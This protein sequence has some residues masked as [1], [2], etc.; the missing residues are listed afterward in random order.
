MRLL[1]PPRF[2]DELASSLWTRMCRRAGL[3]I[4]FLTTRLLGR[5]WTPGFFQ[6]GHIAQMADIFGLSPERMLSL[7]TVFPYATAFMTPEVRES[8]LRN[9][10][11]V[12]TTAR[13]AGVVTQGVSDHVG[14]KRFCPECA[15]YEYRSTGESCWHRS[16][17]L[18]GVMV[19]LK[20]ACLLNEVSGTCTSGTRS[21]SYQLPHEV[22]GTRLSNTPGFS[23]RYLYT[24]AQ[25]SAQAL[26]EPHGF[27]GFTGPEYYRN[28]LISQGLLASDSQIDSSAMSQLGA[29]AVARCLP[30]PMTS[31]HA[32]LS[33][34]KWAV[35]MVRPAAGV[36]FIPLK[37]LLLRTAFALARQDP[38]A[39]VSLEYRAK[40]HFLG[41]NR[42]DMDDRGS[43]ALKRIVDN[44][45]KEGQKLSV[46]AALQAAGCLQWYRH[47]SGDLPLIQAEVN[48]LRCSESSLRRTSARRIATERRRRQACDS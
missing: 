33:D 28:E 20:H 48:R 39:L 44:A 12:G 43:T 34:G 47:C 27:F 45:L 35:P 19:C 11:S 4:T 14:A 37:H 1:A 26:C 18:P 3:P 16:H 36:P 15:N 22:S 2:S 31:L 38:G 29:N 21:W 17:N 5:K 41:R 32:G 25:L 8:A 9:V 24:F 23:R 10:M 7:H 30:R 42:K 46:K 6:A 13:G 40:P